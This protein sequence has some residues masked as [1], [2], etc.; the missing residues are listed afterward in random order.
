LKVTQIRIVR[1]ET[2]GVD[3]RSIEHIWDIIGGI[4]FNF[5][6]KIINIVSIL[7]SHNEW[8]GNEE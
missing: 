5:L 2:S 8:L 6:R 1:E 7:R 3:K 4:I